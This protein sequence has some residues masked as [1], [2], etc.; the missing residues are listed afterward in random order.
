MTRRIQDILRSAPFPAAVFFSAALLF[1]LGVTCGYIGIDDSL[2]TAGCPFVRNGLSW[3]NVSRAFGDIEYGGIWMPVTFVSYMTDVSLFG[4]SAFAFHAV[5]ALLHAVTAVLVY[6]LL[7]RLTDGKSALACLLAAVLWSVHPLRVEAVTYIGARKEILWTMFAVLSL[8]E[9]ARFLDSGRVTRFAGAALFCALA[10]LSKPTA[11]CVPFLLAVLH[12]YR[13]A[14]AKASWKWILPMFAMSVAVA[15]ITLQSQTNP[16]GTG[17]AGV[18]SEPFSWRTLNAAVSL[19]LYFWY[20]AVPFGVHWDYRAVFGGWPVDGTL[21]LL[22]LAAVTAALVWIFLKSS[23]PVREAVL[24]AALMFLFS[25]GPTLGVFAYVNSDQA[26]ADRYSYFPQIALAFLFAFAVAGMSSRRAV[27]AV[28][29]S[30]AALSVSAALCSVPV[31][32]SFESASSAYRRVL[33]KDPGHW[34]ALRVVGNDLC[35]REGRMDEG[36]AMLR[37]SLALRASQT[38]ADALAYALAVRGAEGDFREV[39]RLGSA[40]AADPRLDRGGMMLDALGIAAM[41]EKDWNAAVRF[42]GEGLKVPERNHSY[43][44]SLL[45]LGQSLANAGHEREAVAVLEKAARSRV[46]DVRIRSRASLEAIA[47]SVTRP[48]FLWK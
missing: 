22:T 35:A 44:Y 21:G 29:S 8:I 43:D 27:R 41:R 45:Y 17:A 34:R 6:F 16:E 42:F 23:R 37:R 19:G 47:D 13:R 39:R 9:Y 40:I 14:G 4:N 3:A 36:I 1:S 7:L 15:A 10:L 30:A 31:I 24:F 12:W 25:L 28:L 46:R 20:T 33:E 5:N 26:M 18:L 48:P 2:Y 11:V 38:T 32:R